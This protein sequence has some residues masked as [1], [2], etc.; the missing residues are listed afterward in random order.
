MA[1]TIGENKGLIP[2]KIEF[3]FPI[4]GETIFADS[5]E[6]AQEELKRRE[7]KKRSNIR[8]DKENK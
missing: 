4:E 7:A 2:G 3:N 1:K 5:L 6:E 8:E